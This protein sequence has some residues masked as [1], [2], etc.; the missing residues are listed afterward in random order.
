MKPYLG[1][2]IIVPG[3]RNL[4]ISAVVILGSKGQ[5]GGILTR[6]LSMANFKVTGLNKSELDVTDKTAIRKMI[7]S[8]RPKFLINC[9]A[10]TDVANAENY[11]ND[12]Y[13]I[14]CT[15]L[16]EITRSCVDYS[17]KLIHISTDHVFSGTQNSEYKTDAEKNPVNYYGY[18]KSKGEDLIINSKSLEY[19]ILRTSWLY[20]NSKSDFVN[21]ILD[22]YKS[23]K[24]PISV[25][26]DQFGH[27]T[28]V[29]DL[30]ERII[31]MI[32]LDV[33]P[34]IYHASNSGLTSW[35]EFAREI[36]LKK[37]LDQNRI[38]PITTRELGSAVKRPM[39]ASMDFSAWSEVN[40]EPLR[41]WQLALQE[42]IYERNMIDRDNSFKN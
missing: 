5:L 32:N 8:I 1:T 29:K 34:G 37:G 6:Q 16:E 39:S 28:Y 27:P 40:L 36:A 38:I 21:K 24:F 3:G 35:Y 2:E 20:G 25:V 15:S 30:A 31:V 26:S 23:S 9:A 41:N 18:S 11:K 33:A 19:W 14:N 4:K 42:F 7:N 22:Q 17:V 12:A 13:L 10:W